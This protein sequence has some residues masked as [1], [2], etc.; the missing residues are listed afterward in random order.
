MQWVGWRQILLQ[1]ST[2]TAVATT[3]KRGGVWTDIKA[4]SV[5]PRIPTEGTT[6][7]AILQLLISSNTALTLK[8]SSH[9]E[10]IPFTDTIASTDV[11]VV[12]LTT[13][14]LR[15]ST[16]YRC[17]NRRDLTATTGSVSEKPTETLQEDIHGHKIL[18]LDNNQRLPRGYKL[19]TT[20][21]LKSNLP[22]NQNSDSQRNNIATELTKESDGKTF[23]IIRYLD[24]D[25]MI[26]SRKPEE[27]IS[28][29]MTNI[30]HKI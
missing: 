29:F 15:G 26:W 10:N 5:R 24:D 6:A 2:A 25:I 19:Y 1:K 21:V 4:T 30:R 18:Q 8:M 7:T 20:T 12:A 3:D 14:P 28:R 22:M 11:S 17:T 23:L 13:L 16:I 9:G 27:L